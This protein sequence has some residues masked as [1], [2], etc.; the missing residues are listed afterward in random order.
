[1]EEDGVDLFVQSLDRIP[2]NIEVPLLLDELEEKFMERLR[3]KISI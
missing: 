1:M 3:K 2:E